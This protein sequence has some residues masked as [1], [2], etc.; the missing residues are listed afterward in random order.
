MQELSL[1]HSL[2][3]A[4][5]LSPSLC[6]PLSLSHSLTLSLSL[7][8]SHS[9]CFTLSLSHSLTLSLSLSHS[10]THPLTHSRNLPGG[11]EE[12]SVNFDGSVHFDE[13]AVNFDDGDDF[14]LGQTEE[15]KSFYIETYDKLQSL[16]VCLNIRSRFHPQ[17]LIIYE[18]TTRFLSYY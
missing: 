3:L 6:L 4:L 10:L 9:L 5:S 18:I 13:R 11:M 1:S 8:H 12:R 16:Q 17:T 15:E 7:S 2:T 14:H